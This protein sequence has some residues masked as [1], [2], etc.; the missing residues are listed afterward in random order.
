MFIL[1]CMLCIA[2]IIFAFTVNIRLTTTLIVTE[3]PAGNRTMAFAIYIVDNYPRSI[4][5]V[6][7]KVITLLPLVSIG[8][9]LYVTTDVG[10]WW[11][12]AYTVS[13]ILCLCSKTNIQF[14]KYV[15]IDQ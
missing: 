15:R 8:I 6:Q 14:V 13:V 3:I 1:S 2:V 11:V 7:G 9:F 4:Q 12:I 10:I 5:Y